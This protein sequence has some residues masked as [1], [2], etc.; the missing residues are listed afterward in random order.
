[1][2]GYKDNR[3]VVRASRVQRRM[4]GILNRTTTNDVKNICH[5]R[6]VWP[7]FFIPIT[8]WRHR[9]EDSTSA[10][11]IVLCKTVGSL[12]IGSERSW[13]A[14]KRCNQSKFT[15]MCNWLIFKSRMS[16]FGNDET[17]F[18]IVMNLSYVLQALL[19]LFAQ[20]FASSPFIPLAETKYRFN[21]LY[22]LSKCIFSFK[23]LA[24]TK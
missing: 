19:Y 13:I 21:C 11:S 3:F 14:F 6:W 2:C 23:H 1:M 22:E 8:F 9:I 10:Q 20:S 18:M 7:C 24:K 5:F 4:S 12:V 15:A 16:I 17:F